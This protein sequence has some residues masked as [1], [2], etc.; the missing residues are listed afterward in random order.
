MRASANPLVWGVWGIA[1]T[2][3]TV[4][5]RD[6]LYLALALIATTIVYLTRATSASDAA[7][8]SLV[9]RIGALVSI[10]SVIFNLL[11]H[12]RETPSSSPFPAPCRSS[13]ASSLLMRSPTAS[14]RRFRLPRSSWRRPVSA[15]L[16]IA[17]RCCGLYRIHSLRPESPPSSD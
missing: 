16:W 8:W 12:M 3:V 6:P 4:T 7:T 11:R 1:V 9:V 10:V 17:P 5:T 13:A 2:L 14:R 15:R